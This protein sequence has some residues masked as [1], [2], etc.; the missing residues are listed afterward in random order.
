MKPVRTPWTNA[1]YKLEGGSDENDLPLE[2]NHDADEHE[3]LLSTWELTNEERKAVAD[4]KRIE[5]IIWG[6]EHPPIALRVEEVEDG[7][8]AKA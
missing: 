1:L 4:G 7:S 5:V 6:E 3:I 2:K 8:E